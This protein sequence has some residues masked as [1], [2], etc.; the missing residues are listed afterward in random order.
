[1]LHPLKALQWLPL[2][3]GIKPRLL[4]V[5]LAR[6]SKVN[7]IW[8]SLIFWPYQPFSPVAYYSQ[9]L[10]PSFCHLN[11]PGLCTDSSLCFQCSPLNF[12]ITGCFSSFGS[13]FSCQHLREAISDHSSQNTA[14]L[15][16]CYIFLLICNYLELCLQIFCLQNEH[17]L[18]RL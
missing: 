10:W 5:A 13:Q 15:T 8:P 9:P 17:P 11:I 14:S 18:L 16:F 1:M 6:L 2:P 12:C 7:M 4:T 3:S